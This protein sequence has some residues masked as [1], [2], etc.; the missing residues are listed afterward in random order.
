MKNTKIAEPIRM[1]FSSF[2]I[3]PF[4]KMLTWCRIKW[5][6]GKRARIEKMWA[7]KKAKLRALKEQKA[8]EL[9][10]NTLFDTVKIGKTTICDE[11]VIKESK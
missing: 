10:T 4:K 6:L 7:K 2:N 11:A 9:A 3:L 8:M 5:A 1:D